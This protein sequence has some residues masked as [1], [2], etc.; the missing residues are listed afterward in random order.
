MSNRIW[1]QNYPP[2]VP[3]EINPLEYRSLVD[4]TDQSLARFRDL[5]AYTSMG[6]TLT[7]GDLDP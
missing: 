3:A 2:G 1:L 7:F 4:L 5:P 6:R